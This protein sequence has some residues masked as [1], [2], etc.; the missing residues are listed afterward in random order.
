MLIQKFFDSYLQGLIGDDVSF[1]LLAVD[2]L[3]RT[4]HL[5]VLFQCLSLISEACLGNNGVFHK[6]EG[7]LAD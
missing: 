5:V 2:W 3:D 7:Y 6:F 4:L 1:A